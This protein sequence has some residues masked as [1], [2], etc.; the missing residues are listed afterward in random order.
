MRWMG[1]GKAGKAKVVCDKTKRPVGAG[2]EGLSTPQ[3]LNITAD[4][5][6]MFGIV[7]LS[8]GWLREKWPD[9]TKVGSLS[10][11]FS[12]WDDGDALTQS[13]LCIQGSGTQAQ[14]TLVFGQQ[15][16][17]P[18][19]GMIISIAPTHKPT[20]RADVLLSPDNI[21]YRAELTESGGPAI[22]RRQVVF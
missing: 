2:S 7:T 5:A 13:E 6:D 21:A 11:D 20:H 12:S 22:D 3:A 18:A 8:A 14:A 16:G 9:L 1:E 10:V 15:H 17:Q 19:A 4:D